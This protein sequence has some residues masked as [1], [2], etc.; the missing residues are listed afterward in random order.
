MRLAEA[1][2]PR[3]GSALAFVGAGGKTSAIFALADDLERPVVVTTT[4]H[5]GAWQAGLAEEHFRIESADQLN[6]IDFNQ[7]KTLLITGLAGKDDRLAGLSRPGLERLFQR[8]REQVFPLLIEADGARQRPLKAPATYEP[9]IPDWVEGV[10]T[11]AG[12]G[13]LGQPLTADTVHRPE[14]FSK[15]SGCEP[16][17]LIEGGHLRRMLASKQGGLK[18]IPSGARRILF[19]NQAEDA[20]LQEAGFQLARQLLGVYDRVLVG[21]LHEPAQAGPIFSLHAPTAGVILAAGGSDRLG[22][23]KQLLDWQGAPFVRQVAQKALES[24]LSPVIAVI[25]AHREGVEEALAGL[26]VTWV[27]NP[28]WA[29]GQ[30]TSMQAGLAALPE[31]ADS[32]LFLLSDQPQIGSDLIQALLERYAIHRQPITAPRVHGQR[33]NPV[34]FSNAAFDSL[35]KVVG[36]RGGRAVFDQFAVDWLDWDDA[37]ILWDV[38]EPGDYQ[39]LL[40]AFQ[41]QH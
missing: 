35:R 5:L 40:E 7:Q 3:R 25:G 19:L 6:Q 32:A 11:M 9:V 26:D 8:C 39:R 38:D 15:I 30:S 41:S 34:L 23:A 33:A 16:G 36:D 29:E 4:T 2:G 31:D 27:H 10:V 18:N 12:L 22:A 20:R 14:I 17:E 37:R 1:I 21:S 24:G 28:D 13:G